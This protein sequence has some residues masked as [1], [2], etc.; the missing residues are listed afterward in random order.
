MPGF[1]SVPLFLQF[2]PGSIKPQGDKAIYRLNITNTKGLKP[3]EIDVPAKLM[4]DLY[5]YKIELRHQITKRSGVESDHLFLTTEGKEWTLD[6]GGLNKALNRLNLP[7]KVVPHRC[8]HT[9]ATHT[10]SALQS[11]KSTKF[12]PLIYLRDRLGHA[13]RDKYD[14]AAEDDDKFHE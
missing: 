4:R 7:F 1:G 5:G 8:R 14:T 6:G 10:L 11:K 9:Y 2:Y 13:N 3:R 12:E